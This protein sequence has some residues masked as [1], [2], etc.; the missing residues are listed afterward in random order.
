MK[1]NYAVKVCDCCF[2]IVKG[3]WESKPN[4]WPE[5]V[6]YVDPNNNAKKTGFKPKN[7]TLF[8]MLKH[9]VK[10]YVSKI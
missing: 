4:G 7:D 6:P 5:D 10:E 1:L 8:A 2:V 9:L 3:M